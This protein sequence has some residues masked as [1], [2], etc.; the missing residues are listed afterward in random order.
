MGTVTAR[1]TFHTKGGV[2]N[3]AV[4]S[5]V[6]VALVLTLGGAVSWGQVPPDND[7]SDAN[8][9]T[10]GGRNA[11]QNN[12][13]G[14]NTAYGASALTNGNS[15]FG[16]TATGFAALL[17]NTTGSRNTASGVEALESNSSGSYNTTYGA[18]ALTSNSTG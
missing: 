12:T 15:G 3:R 11:L 5:V 10:G 13:G 17:G 16:N 2:M 18:Y 7:K 6:V 1:N 9:N 14:S 4:C 8:G